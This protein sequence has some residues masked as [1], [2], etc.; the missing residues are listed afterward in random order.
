MEEL[1]EKE[2]VNETV[3]EPKA[4][5]KKCRKEKTRLEKNINII[6]RIFMFVWT[7]A[8]ICVVAVVLDKFY[9]FL[10][11]YQQ[12]YD[13]TRPKLAMEEIIVEFDEADVDWL[14]ANNTNSFEIS[15]FETEETL[16]QYIA[17][18]LK[19]KKVAYTT[20][21]GEHIEERP[22]Y[23]VT[24]DGE[25][26]A[27]VRLKKQE[28]TAEYGHPLWELREVEWSVSPEKSCSV[29]VP[30]NASVYV[31]GILL[32]EEYITEINKENKNAM[33]FSE[34][35]EV[36]T[37]PGYKTYYVDGFYMDPVVTA[38]DFSGVP[39]KLVYEEE[40]K[41]YRAD[42]GSSDTIRQEIEE[43]VI[44][45][46]KDYALVV[47]NDARHSVL[48]KYFVEGS[49]LLAGIK[50]YPSQWYDDHTATGF[51]NESIRELVVFSDNALSVR[52]YVEQYMYV[53]FSGKIEKLV[54]EKKVYF[55]KTD[56]EWKVSG[57]AFE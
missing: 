45:F 36:V 19:G 15:S 43:T 51:Q 27:N 28:K 41:M 33:Y 42:F 25:P 47:T 9:C 35:S 29:T 39:M 13:E 24:L 22:V 48:D 8:C 18:Y 3:E 55:V 10:K 14:L 49:A 56:G 2:P 53:P 30:E 21:T 52:A 38:N 44:Q 46:L 23:V 32:S 4:K 11:E 5:Q 1:K 7:I 12:V 54:T 57:M 34:F 26:F 37:L 20:K 17:D 31:N 50:E 6:Y 40:N 16:R